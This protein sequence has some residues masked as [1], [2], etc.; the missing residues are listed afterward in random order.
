MIQSDSA[1]NASRDANHA[2]RRGGRAARRTSGNGASAAI[3]NSIQRVIPAYQILGEESLVAI[4]Q[5]ADWILKEVG[6]EFRGDDVALALFRDAGAE[7]S[8]NRVRLDEGHAR[9]LCGTAPAEYKMHGR[10]PENSFVLGGNHVV[11]MPGYGSPFVTDLDQGRRYASLEDFRNFVKMAYMSTW[12]HHSGGTVCEPVDVPVNKRHLD[13]VYTHLRYSTKPFMGGVTAPDRAEDSLAMARLVFGEAFMEENA[14]IQANINVN[15]PLIY[16]DT[17]SGALRIYAAANQSVAVS[18][19]IFGGAMGP[20]S[21]AAI[22]AQTLAEGMIGIALTQLVRKGCPVVFG[23]FHSTMNLKSGALT[24]GSPEANLSAFAMAQLGRRL[25]VPVRSTNGGQITAANS[26]DGQAMQDSTSSMWASILS[27]ANQIWHAAGWLEGGLTMSYEKFVLD[28]DHCGMM[29]RMIQGLEV[30][31]EE[32]ARD[33]Y[34]ESGPGDNFFSTSHTMDHFST[35]N[36]QSDMIEAGPYETWLE[37][38]CQTAEQRATPKWK[39][40]L[41]AYEAPPIDPG[42]DEALKDFI[43]RRKS[44]VPD[45]WY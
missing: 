33:S 31:D 19:A 40:M 42:V 35:A 6:V 34:L 25:G 21:Q 30:N 7:V 2:V 4:E 8:G 38:G 43:H 15:S 28:L 26:A 29:L 3:S 1:L 45:A 44:A 10:D 36:Y 13:M 18:P 32:L 39:E 37:N 9:H 24:F 20:V 11:L 41:N 14:V 5:Q 23:S 12:L 17:M 16:D 22:V 27:G